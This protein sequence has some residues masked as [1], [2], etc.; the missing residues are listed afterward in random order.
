MSTGV[1]IFQGRPDRLPSDARV[2]VVVARYNDTITRR[3]LDG[4]VATF[5]AVRP[6]S[7]PLMRTKLA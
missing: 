5:V 3:M 6:G 7:S 2:A 4:A 1:N